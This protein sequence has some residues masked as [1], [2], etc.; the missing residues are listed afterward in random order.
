MGEF[1]Q[2]IWELF[3]IVQLCLPWKCSLREGHSLLGCHEADL[4]FAWY[5]IA[6]LFSSMDTECY[7]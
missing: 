3:N 5:L 7:P 4:H 1:K 6:S 2:V